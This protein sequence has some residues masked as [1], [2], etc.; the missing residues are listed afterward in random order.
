M[1]ESKLKNLEY[2]HAGNTGDDKIHV[3]MVEDL[4]RH[5]ADRFIKEIDINN[6]NNLPPGKKIEKIYRILRRII[7]QDKLMVNDRQLSSIV[8]DIYEDAFEFGPVSSL[9]EDEKVTE[10]MINDYN[11]V[12]VEV[13]GIIK[14]TDITFKNRQHVRNL[15]E[16]IISPLGLRIDE[17]FPMADSRLK[18]GSRINIV[19][20][21]VSANGSV[22]LTIRKFRKNLLSMEDLISHGSL[23]CKVASFIE[24][25]INCRLNIIVSGATSTGK[26]TFLN[27]IAN[28]IP[29]TER[30]ITIEETLELNLR[31]GHVISM[32]GRPPNIEGRGEITLRKLVRNSLRMRPDR[33]IVGEIRGPEA[34]D[35]LQAMNT[36]HEGSMT[37]VHANSP[38]DLISRLETMLLMSGLNLNPSSARRII[39][40]SVDL[41]IH[42]ER[43]ENGQRY[44]SKISGIFWPDARIGEFMELEIRDLI[45]SVKRDGRSDYD[46]CKNLQFLFEKINRRGKKIDYGI[47]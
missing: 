43:N 3:S 44:L 22:V 33:I 7:L 17:S 26:T 11:E 29:L 14:K 37:T 27:I 38:I 46:F 16:K 25:C 28:F 9:M 31:T 20:S 2:E 21:P 13:G 47:F 34:V 32:E 10:V 23:T 40:S 8:R 45:T 5:L 24:A 1:S 18:D 36:G 41:I 4:N 39:A 19:I 35:V 15:A 42:F 6:L 30:I 12:F